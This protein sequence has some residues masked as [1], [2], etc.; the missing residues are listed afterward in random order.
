M[1][2]NSAPGADPVAM[3]ELKFEVRQPRQGKP[4]CLRPG[5]GKSAQAIAASAAPERGPQHYSG[6]SLD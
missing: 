4:R 2:W 6:A 3:C 1:G 5:P